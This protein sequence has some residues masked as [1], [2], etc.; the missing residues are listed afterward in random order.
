MKILILD[1]ETAPH[2]VHV[3]GLFQQNVGLPQLIK[4][5]SILCIA[6]KW[7]GDEKVHF[8]S[9]K[10]DGMEGMLKGVH[11]LLDEADVVV[12]Y[13][14]KRFDIP[15][16]QGQFLE[17][18]I[19][20]P[21]PFK[22]VD[23]YETA[24]R[25]FKLASNKLDYVARLLKLPL[26]LNTGGHSLWVDCMAGDEKAWRKMKAYNKHD[27]LLTEMVYEKFGTYIR[28]HPNHALYL[29]ATEPTVCVNCGSTH[30][31]TKAIHYTSLNKYQRYRCADCGKWMRGRSS[32]LTKEERLRMLVEAT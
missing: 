14:S 13:N 12:G 23:L 4:P 19:T 9:I 28:S 11:Q 21:S 31:H 26:K 8:Y 6:A 2:N 3:W 24:K 29:T 10:K 16:I 30:I 1:I 25:Q 5:G 27:V 32:L 17:Y 20:P 7:Y 22:Q 18:G 15:W